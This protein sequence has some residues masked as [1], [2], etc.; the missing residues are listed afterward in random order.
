MKSRFLPRTPR[1][2]AQLV[3]PKKGY[4]QDAGIISLTFTRDWL[5]L[6]G[7]GELPMPISVRDTKTGKLVMLLLKPEDMNQTELEVEI[8]AAGITIEGEKQQRQPANSTHLQ[9]HW[10]CHFPNSGN[11]KLRLI[12]RLCHP[13][14]QRTLQPIDC[15]IKVVQF[16][17][18]TQRQL[19]LVSAFCGIIALIGTIFTLIINFSLVL[20]ILGLR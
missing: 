17:H 3:Y 6:P 13:S 1:Y 7:F 15:S 10:T 19:R 5:S 12:P 9:Y 11:L 2:T 20:H 16:D 18:L 4:F 14:G 8:Q